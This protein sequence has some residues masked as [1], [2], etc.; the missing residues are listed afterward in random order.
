M[1]FTHAFGR[2]KE[3]ANIELKKMG[4]VIKNL[5]GTEKTITRK[6]FLKKAKNTKNKN[7]GPSIV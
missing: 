3:P 7:Y 5:V 6:N 4:N 1:N 2:I